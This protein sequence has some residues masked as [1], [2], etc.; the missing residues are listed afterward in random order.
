MVPWIATRSAL[1]CRV[2]A[3]CAATA[4]CVGPPVELASDAA[5]AA[6]ISGIDADGAAVVIAAGD[7]ARCRDLS[8]AIATSRLVSALVEA[9]P[10]ARI[11]TVGD[12]AYPRGRPAELAECYAPTWGAF[13]ARTAPSPGNHDYQT[14][15]GAPYFDYFDLYDRDPGARE[16][17]Y[18]SFEI[19]SWQMVSLNSM[20]PIH[21]GAAQLAWLERELLSSDATC[22][23]A[24]WHH[25]RFSSSLHGRQRGDIGRATGPLWELLEAHGVDVVVNGHAH[26]Y[27][28]FAPQSTAGQGTPDGIRQF[29]AGMGGASLDRAL[30][31]LPN[32]E[33]LNADAHGVLVLVLRAS[34]YE[35][36]FIGVDGAVHDT[37]AGAAQCH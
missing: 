2:A 8:P 27:E 16:R 12:H 4:G 14:D 35:W 23:L 6:V 22:T 19:G 13:N 31:P 29:V 37:S 20:L 5:L 32:S 36:R 15:D 9:L 26:M 11:I 21:A 25:P 33:V 10:D 18:Y 28:R 17:G 7:I 30:E 24:Y 3:L 34:S 1:S